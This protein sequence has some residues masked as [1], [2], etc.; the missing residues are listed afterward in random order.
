MYPEAEPCFFPA[1]ALALFSR[2]FGMGLEARKR[3]GG[4]W[5]GKGALT[6]NEAVFERSS[7]RILRVCLRGRCGF[8]C[9]LILVASPASVRFCVVELNM[10]RSRTQCVVFL[11]RSGSRDVRQELSR[12]GHLESSLLSLLT[13]RIYRCRACFWYPGIASSSRVNLA[14]EA[15]TYGIE[16]S[17]N[18]DG[19]A[20]EL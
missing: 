5:E 7:A 9:L 2:V 18:V 19:L 11:S 17:S 1:L 4:E 3:E 13:Y 16:L 10:L 8:Y 15:C 14:A 20:I 12:C 6:Q